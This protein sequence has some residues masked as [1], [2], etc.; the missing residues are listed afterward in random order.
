M[1]DRTRRAAQRIEGRPAVPGIALGPLVRLA[2]AK[3]DLR[4]SRTVAEEHRAL[5]KALLAAKADLS[6][7]AQQAGDD[8]AEAI[9]SFQIALLED[10][11]LGEPAFALIAGGEAAHRA[12]SAALASQIASFDGA[13]DAYFRARASDLRD[14]RDRVLRHLAGEA[15]QT[16]PSGVIVA[17]DDMPPSMFL[18]TDWRDGGLVLRRGSPSSHVAILARSRGVPMIVGVDVDRLEN[19]TDALLDGEAGFLIVNPDSDTQAIYHQRRAEQSEAR[20]AMASFVGP[21]RTATGEPVQVMINVTGLAELR[22]LD[23]AHVDGIG[24]MRTE[25]LFQGREKLPTEEEQYQTYKRMLEWAAGKPVTIRTL[26]A[27]GDK[28]IAGL[29]QEGDINPFL[30]VRGVRLSLR[31]LDVF[32]A[33]LRALA[34]AATSGNLKVM[35]PMVTAPEE[36]DQC[37]ALFEQVL[38]ELRR[39]DIEAKMPPLGMMVEV[40]AAALTIEDF[41]ADFFSIGS[42]DLIQYVAAASRDEPQLAD[43]ARPSRAVFSLIRHVV[44]YAD[45][46]GRETSLCGDLA[47]EPG[48]VAA[49]LDQG[50]R[51]F[52]VAPGALGPVRAAIARYTGPAA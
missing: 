24:L 43:L 11:N 39:E 23:P 40:P 45:R 12:W 20:Q 35:I 47:G 52:S 19:G 10:D 6:M 18:A 49:L 17:A 4:Q 9:L 29:T 28:P 48:Q 7:L 42:N 41:D 3:H 36:L 37:R 50:L 5:V 14:L 33:Q 16:L 32:R 13:D 38:E 8:D 34:R 15:D 21:A 46:A 26:D 31:H 1:D 44:E 25:F 30:G 2:P 51:I 22:G 27:G